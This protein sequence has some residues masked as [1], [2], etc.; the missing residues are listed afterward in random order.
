M[1]QKKC[2]ELLES[3]QYVKKRGKVDRKIVM[4]C[5]LENA[6]QAIGTIDPGCEIYGFTKGQFSLIDILEHCLDQIGPSDITVSTWSAASGDIRA[7]FRLMQENRIKS[8]RFII[9]SSFK[10]RKPEFCKELL[11]KFGAD[12]IRVSSVHAKFM[13]MKNDRYNLVIRTS[14][15]LNNNPRFENFEISDDPELMSFMTEIVDEIWKTQKAHEGFEC[16]RSAND[17]KFSTLFNNGSIVPAHPSDLITGKL[18]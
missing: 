15:N 6:K 9:D 5:R 8:M 13:T 17:N 14:M 12:C 11:Q 1:K 7:A 4:A 3:A 18:A 2:L 16:S 10:G